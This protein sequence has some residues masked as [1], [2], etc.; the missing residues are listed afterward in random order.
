M[1]DLAGLVEH[2]HLF[3]GIVVLCEDIDLRDEVERQLVLET[4][5]GDGLACQYLTVLLVELLHGSGTGATGCLIGGYM[6]THD[7]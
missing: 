4:L 1:H 7:V 6:H 5:D 3:L 2:L